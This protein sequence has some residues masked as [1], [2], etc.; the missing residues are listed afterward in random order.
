MGICIVGVCG[1]GSL[2]GWAVVMLAAWSS[3]LKWEHSYGMRVTARPHCA[4]LLL[5][6]CALVYPQAL[7]EEGNNFTKRRRPAPCRGALARS[8]GIAVAGPEED[9]KPGDRTRVLHA[10]M[11]EQSSRGT[12]PARRLPRIGGLP[13]SQLTKQLSQCS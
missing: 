9:A 7:D 6:C 13:V 10:E 2:L 5:P 8:T 3:N 12:T 11:P 4:H 1:L